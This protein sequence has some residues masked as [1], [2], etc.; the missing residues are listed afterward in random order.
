LPNSDLGPRSTATSTSLR[1][2]MSERTGGRFQRRHKGN[3]G[4]RARH[5]SRT[6]AGAPVPTPCSPRARR[7]RRTRPLSCTP[8]R[9]GASDTATPAGIPAENAM[10]TDDTTQPM[11]PQPSEVAPASPPP[12]INRF[13]LGCL[14]PSARSAATAPGGRPLVRP[15]LPLRCSTRPPRPRSRLHRVAR[16]SGGCVSTVADSAQ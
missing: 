4:G 7:F 13:C 1:S 8:Y 2:Q 5:S 10:Q 14:T 15:A 16:L 12:P 11:Q 9:A 3:D 6:G